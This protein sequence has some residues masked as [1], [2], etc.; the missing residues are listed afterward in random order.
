[1][2]NDAVLNKDGLDEE[3]VDLILYAMEIGMSVQE[4]QTFFRK[5]EEE[6]ELT[7][8]KA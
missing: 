4:I 5:S 8:E 7:T 1:M 2:V 6:I 3:W